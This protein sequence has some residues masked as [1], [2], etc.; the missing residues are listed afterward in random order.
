MRAAVYRSTGPAAEVLEVVELEL[1]EPGPGEVR[2]RIVTSG[3]NPTDWKRRAGLTGRTPDGFQVPHHDGAGV[4][5]AVGS[6]V[7][8]LVVGQRVWLYLAAFGNRY[9][10]A[11]EYAVVPAVRAV[12]LPDG[13]SD[14]LGACLGVPALTAAHCLG[15]NPGALQGRT[16][17]VAGGAGAVGH[18]AIELAKH[19]GATVVATVSS[20][21][22]RALAEDAGADLV[23]RYPDQD[24]S[25]QIRDVVQHVDRIVE[26][27]PAT[28]LEL[29]LAVLRDGGTIA[30]YAAEGDL[31]LPSGKLMTANVTLAF[32]LLYGVSSDQ[33][34]DAVRWTSDALAVGALSALPVIP[35]ALERVADAQDRVEQ[36]AVG[37]VVLS[38]AAR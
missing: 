21:E 34:A 13:A 6:G 36:A 3:I 38:V 32:V 15:G 22:K 35:Y 33:L 4:V 19:A 12:P 17:L 24:V 29:D 11:A 10:T 31:V 9:G 23:V 8:G 14:E 5:D 7:D 28:N 20:D 25:R 37:K 18:Y 27:A 1:P 16:V 26:V 2:V 30:T